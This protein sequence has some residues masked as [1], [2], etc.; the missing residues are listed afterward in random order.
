MK[1]LGK[2][3]PQRGQPECGL[4]PGNWHHQLAEN[5]ARRVLCAPPAPPPPKVGKGPVLPTVPPAQR[6]QWGRRQHLL[7][8]SCGELLR[9]QIWVLDILR[10]PTNT[11]LQ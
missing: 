9:I 4:A 5:E 10:V 8:C 3:T 11:S 1:H 6:L 2:C 7:G